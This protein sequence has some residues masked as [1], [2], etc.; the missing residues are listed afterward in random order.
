M[1]AVVVDDVDMGITHII[2]GDD[3][4]NNAFRQYHLYQAMGATPPVFAHI[5]LIH[6]QDGAKL[7]KRHGAMGIG[8][9]QAMGFLPEAMRNYLLRLGWGKGDADI[10][11]TSEAVA[12]FDIAD[13]GKAPSR[14]D[15]DKLL[16]LN[17]HYLRNLPADTLFEAARPFLQEAWPDAA[18][19]QYEW[20]RQGLPALQE[21]ARTLCDV[22]AMAGI[23]LGAP[24][25]PRTEAATAAFT[26]DARKLLQ[27]V[28]PVI[29]TA[30]DFTHDALFALCKEAATAQG[31]KIGV[32][33]GAMRIALTGDTASPSIFDIMPII[34]RDE[35]LQRLQGAA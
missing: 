32:L 25:L 4:L 20:L 21:R 17:G 10:V 26:P 11:S 34:G 35:T 33:A 9:Y 23:Y 22:A 27:A 6:G 2:R 19:H 15:L 18:A 7:S 28:L 24:P 12:L 30:P 8:E 1:L 3:H 5:P 16:H 14:F 29:E 13:V 31:V